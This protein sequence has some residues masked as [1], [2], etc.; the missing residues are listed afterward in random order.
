MKKHQNGR[1]KLNM[2][3]PHRTSVI[4]N[5]IIHLINNG[6]L[7][8]TKARIKVVQQVT[9]KIVTLARK[10]ADFNTIRRV[11]SLLPYSDDAVK[12]LIQEIAPK[13]VTGPDRKSTRLNS[14]H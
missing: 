9:E 11:K 7:H 8:T 2:K 4:R 6:F 14:S 1:S 13:Y 3:T 10:G 5:Q 12:K